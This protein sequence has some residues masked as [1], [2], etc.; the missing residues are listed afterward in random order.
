MMQEEARALLAVDM[1]LKDYR[2]VWQFQTDA[3]AEVATGTSDLLILVE[4]P[5]VITCGRGSHAGNLGVTDV[6]IVEVERGGDVTWH[7]PGQMVCYPLLRLEGDERDLHR[8]L[9]NCEE[10]AIR[11]LASFGI[12]GTRRE[13]LTGVWVEE[14]KI[15]SI[16]IA[17]RQW[18]TFHG[19]ALNVNNDP[20]EFSCIRPCGLDPGV[21]TSLSRLLGFEPPLALV[22][23]KFAEHAAEVFQ[24]R[25]MGGVYRSRVTRPLGPEAMMN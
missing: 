10:L 6:P 21:M 3:I 14:R 20:A 25:I 2:E 18:V 12:P 4:H 9:R 5:R 17:V 23:D 7:A 8:H 1:G 24:R 13:G 15:A 11:V 16:G 19:I 22:A